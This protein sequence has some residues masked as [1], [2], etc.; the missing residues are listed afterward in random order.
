MPSFEVGACRAKKQNT[1]TARPLPASLKSCVSVRSVPTN[2]WVAGIFQAAGMRAV[3]RA[4]ERVASAVLAGNRVIGEQF[5]YAARR[6]HSA[7]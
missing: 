6:R 5:Q 3:T 1:N 4:N 7:T 2:I